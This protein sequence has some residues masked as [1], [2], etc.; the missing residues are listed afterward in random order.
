MSTVAGWRHFVGLRSPTPPRGASL[1]TTNGFLLVPRKFAPCRTAAGA[2][3]GIFSLSDVFDI[4]YRDVS[5]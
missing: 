3:T 1:L 4:P 2:M 5:E